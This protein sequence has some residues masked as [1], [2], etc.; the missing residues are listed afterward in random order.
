MRLQ[1]DVPPSSPHDFKLLAKGFVAAIKR[2][3]LA[4]DSALK[5]LF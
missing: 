2:A 4:I 1:S 3:L 5:A